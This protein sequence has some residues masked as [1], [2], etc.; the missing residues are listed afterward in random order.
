MSI[1]EELNNLIETLDI[2]VET[3]VFSKNPPETY[4]VMT[5]LIDTYGLFAD[6]APLADIQQVRLSLFSKVNYISIKNTLSQTLLGADFTIIERRYIGREDDSGYHH[7]SID[8]EKE[9]TTEEEN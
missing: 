1:L 7:Y 3:A 9:Y 6:N 4:I 8:V 2:P 5:P